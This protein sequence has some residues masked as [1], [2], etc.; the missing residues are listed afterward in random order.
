MKLA[1]MQPYFMPYIGYWQ[2]INSVDKFVIFDD[3]NYINKGWINRNKILVNGEGKYINILLKGASQNK[4]INEIELFYEENWQNKL[5]QTVKN[6]YKKAPCFE[7]AFPVIEHAVMIEEKNLA[8]YLKKIICEITEYLEISTEILISS[9]IPK[10]NG[11]KGQEK[12]CDICERLGANAYINPIGGTELYSKDIFA[13]KGM[14]L[15]FIQTEEIMY[16]QYSDNFV[17]WLSIIDVMM[18][19]DKE[20][21]KQM[22]GKY[23]LK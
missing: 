7:E 15:Y 22:L 1:V 21:I 3:V 13:Q 6:S 10:N 9:E 5:L 4:R 2:L 11:L 19:N 8:E 14:E 17:P 23:T 12:I 20:T 18:F 16:K